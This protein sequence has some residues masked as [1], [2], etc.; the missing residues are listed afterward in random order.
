M[1]SIKRILVLVLVLSLAAGSM[2]AGVLA[3]AVAP[4]AVARGLAY[5]AQI[6]NDDGGFPREKGAPSD[7]VNT[8]WVVMALAAAG[9]DPEGA[10]WSREGKSPV[11]YLQRAA[12]DSPGT[13]ESARMLL[14]LAAAGVEGRDLVRHLEGLQQ[15]DGQFCNP[16]LGEEDLVNAHIWTVLALSSQEDGEWDM[17][18]ARQWLLEVQNDDGGFGWHVGGDSDTD[19]TAAAVQALRVLGES[20]YRSEGINKALAFIKGRQT[21]DGGFN[22]SDLLGKASNSASGSWVLQAMASLGIDPDSEEWLVGGLGVVDELTKRQRSDGAFEWKEGVRSAPAQI[23]AYAVMGLSGKAHPVN[24]LP[25]SHDFPDVASF[26]WAADSVSVMVVEGVMQGYPDGRFRP[27]EPVT[28]EEFTTMM[29]KALG[30]DPMTSQ[31]SLGFD[32]L[33]RT[34][35]SHPYVM[36]AYHRGIIQGRSPERFD[37]TAGIS[38]AELA[39]ILVNGLGLD[40]VEDGQGFPWYAG[41]VS[42][43]G[44]LELL[45]PRFDTGLKATRAQC[46][47]SIHQFLKVRP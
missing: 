7:V 12:V 24:R 18:K 13:T 16:E 44:E 19:D 4:D 33:P 22:A 8:S 23:T 5:F 27:E 9:E 14:A 11:A 41:S 32:D 34:R 30:I 2:A 15:P 40:P 47:Y 17:E 1:R 45:Y 43:A 10:A 6:Q 37:P 42:L 20:A 36:A 3:E 28:R 21:L 46:A 35:W 39:T 38:G 26:H 29:V 25:G 31:V